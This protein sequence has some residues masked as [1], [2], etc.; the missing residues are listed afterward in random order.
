MSE[1]VIAGI[2][3]IPVG[4]HWHLSL[5]N[6]SAAAIQ[7]ARRDAGGLKPQAMYIGNFLAPVVSNQSNL[8]AL[9]ADNVGL[10]GIEAYAIEAAEASGGAALRVG[11]LAVASGYVDVAL[12]VGVEKFTDQVGTGLNTAVAQ[13]GDYDYEAVQGVTPAVQAGLLMQRYLHQYAPPRQ[14][15]G[16]L[17]VLCHANAVA[18][19]NAMFRRP[20][21]LEA[22]QRAAML[23]DP[24]NLFDMAAYADGAA[25][26]I[27]TRPALLPKDLSH[28]AVRLSASSAVIDTLALHDRSAPLAFEAVRHSTAR[29]CR[30]AGIQAADVDLFELSDNFSIY[31]VL[32]LEAAGFAARGEGWK[33]VHNGEFSRQGR[34]PVCTMGGMKGRG[35][36]LGAAGV[37]Q[38]VEAALQLRDEAGENQVAGAR[39]A[40][41]QSLGGP[42]STVVTH[43]L[44]R[45]P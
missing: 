20:L 25:A 3:Q 5:R 4:E 45:Y 7:A 27:L 39:R 29:A 8:G 37:Y 19:P 38:A 35:N 24:L 43:V 14:A 30:K 11:Y 9:L 31:G 36:P 44:E 22:Y 28:P 18:N 10:D 26:I 33:L 15:L 21:S 13:S 32:S 42:A 2:G 34:L 23:S 41:V 12:V 40:L 6:L 1:V 16:A 17:P